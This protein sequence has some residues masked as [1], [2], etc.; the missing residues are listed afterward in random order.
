M[1]WVTALL[2]S[3]L[4]GPQNAPGA[5]GGGPRGITPGALMQPTPAPV[6][7][8][9]GSLGTAGEAALGGPI[10]SDI[11]ILPP[12]GTAQL[13]Q[14]IQAQQSRAL[15]QQTDPSSIASILGQLAMGTQ[16]RPG[17][18]PQAPGMGP[19]GMTGGGSRLEI[20]PATGHFRWMTT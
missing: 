4:Q 1:A 20:D 12:T 19:R 13:Q 10:P 16:Q 5:P 15:A 2:G 3:T 17:S 6:G 8:A 7:I 9:P 11:S 18:A 14:D